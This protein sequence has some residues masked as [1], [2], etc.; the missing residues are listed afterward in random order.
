MI[1]YLYLVILISLVLM[2]GSY[3]VSESKEGGWQ[4]GD[5]FD[6]GKGRRARAA[7][8]VAQ[9]TSPGGM[10]Q[11]APAF[12]AP[13]FPDPT[14]QPETAPAQPQAQPVAMTTPQRTNV[15]PFALV[16]QSM[17][18][19]VVNV[20]ASS[21]KPAA[22]PAKDAQGNPTRPRLRFA[23]PFSGVA[24]ESIGS[25]I[26]VTAGGHILTNYHVVENARQIHVTVFNELGTK[27]YHA[28]LV[29][30]DPMRDL[31]LLKVEPE[32]PLV[33]A[34]L[35]N[36][37]QIQV[38]DPVIAIGSPFGLDQTVSKGIISSKRKV[39]SIGDVVH[40]G[41]LQTDAAINRGNSG[42][43]LVGLDGRLVGV[44]TAIFTSTDAFSGV[45]FAVPVSQARKFLEEQINLPDVPA[46]NLKPPAGMAVTP[47]AMARNRAAEMGRQTQTT[48]AP[49]IA[50]DAALPHDDRG[51][52]QN[53]HQI[54]PPS[55]PLKQ[56]VWGAVPAAA[57][58]GG[59]TGAAAPP[60]P[61][62]AVM[63]H[64]DRGPCQNCHQLL[65]PLGGQGQ[66]PGGMM[67]PG[68]AGGMTVAARGGGAAPPIPADAAM[69]HDDRGPCADCHEMLP[70]LNPNAS[71]QP[72]RQQMPRYQN[73]YMFSPGGAIGLPTNPLD[74]GKGQGRGMG[75]GLGK[76]QGMGPMGQPAA[77][78]VPNNMDQALGLNVAWGGPSG[79]LGFDIGT[80]TP[81]MAKQ[82]NSPYKEGVLIRGVGAGTKAA[83]AGF[84]A[85]DII[86]KIGGGWVKSLQDFDDRLA[87]VDPGEQARISIV[88]KGRRQDI[89]IRVDK[90]PKKPRKNS[91]QQPMTVMPPAGKAPPVNT[92]QPP[93]QPMPLQQPRVQLPQA[94]P[95]AAVGPL[96]TW[97]ARIPNM[98]LPVAQVTPQPP[99]NGPNMGQ[100]VA[101]QAQQMVPQAQRRLP[102]AKTEFEWMGMEIS[103]IDAALVMKKPTLKNKK[104][105]IISEVNIGSA[106]DRAGIQSNDIVQSIN[107]MPVVD[108]MTL[109]QA[110]KQATKKQGGGAL[111]SIER[112]NKPM[113][114][115][116]Q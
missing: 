67:A 74:T 87:R 5:L 93:I 91:V 49:P 9:N 75:Q 2:V 38:G 14:P 66:A 88:R 98:A 52:C 4:A 112:R 69:P 55:K 84:K 27:R 77:P 1:R 18:P 95:V 31:S 29:N 12:T 34:A 16:A 19:S 78:V 39:V 37:E 94:T 36:S 35:G 43:P 13:S 57:V 104:G 111:L 100:P 25:G 45:G 99:M 102:P 56:G 73:R 3:W 28:M 10:M 115:A 26:I 82:A 33:P 17:M 101:P 30:S 24:M 62:D 85:G 51:P 40:R 90:R 79:T 42:G 81:E 60:I 76:G 8:Q 48:G 6:A 15:S 107:G 50:A 116:L 92:L 23:N 106:A 110:I 105:G 59:R 71:A 108:A 7:A 80:L 47:V 109:D 11:P 32:T 83:A 53:C 89:K 63:P 64:D 86:F 68:M 41:L 21:A 72:V 114:V 61:V 46:P 22:P 97:L 103:P 58:G 54:L 113:F 44:N 96:A 65:P 70:P 20:S